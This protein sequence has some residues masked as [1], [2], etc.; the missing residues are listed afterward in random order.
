MPLLVGFIQQGLIEEGVSGKGS[1]LPKSKLAREDDCSNRDVVSEKRRS[2]EIEAGYESQSGCSA[3]RG[4]TGHWLRKRR[5][6][7]LAYDLRGVWLLC[8]KPSSLL[9]LSQ[10]VPQ[11]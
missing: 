8:L 7:H 11:I 1:T 6:V 4:A 3:D 9:R 10:P 5:I 2:R